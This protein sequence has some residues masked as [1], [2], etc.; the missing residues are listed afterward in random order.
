MR[1]VVLKY[2]QVEKGGRFRWSRSASAAVM[3]W[4]PGLHG[5]FTSP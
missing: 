5:L 3:Q 1:A 4:R 2:L